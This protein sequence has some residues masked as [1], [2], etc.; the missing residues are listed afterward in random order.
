[1]AGCKYSPP[2]FISFKTCGPEPALP[3]PADSLIGGLNARS[4]QV[5]DRSPG[6][7]PAQNL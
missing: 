1:M 5:E 7:R 4:S 6:C 3:V 2:P